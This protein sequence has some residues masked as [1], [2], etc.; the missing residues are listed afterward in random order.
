MREP[1]LTL[2]VTS[3]PRA[4]SRR[5]PPSA[6]ACCSC[7]CS[8]PPNHISTNDGGAQQDARPSRATS[9]TTE[10]MTPRS[11]HNLESCTD[12]RGGGSRSPVVRE[13]R[14]AHKASLTALGPAPPPH[15]FTYCQSCVAAVS[16][17]TP[18][19]HCTAR[20]PRAPSS[21]E[22]S[23]RPEG[24]LVL[25][26]FPFGPQ[27]QHKIGASTPRPRHLPSLSPPSPPTWRGP[28]QPEA[29]LPQRV[30]AHTHA[31]RTT[32]RRLPRASAHGGVG[33][34]RAESLP[35]STHPQ[36][37]SPHHQLDQLTLMG[38][39]P[40]LRSRPPPPPRAV[41]GVSTTASTTSPTASRSICTA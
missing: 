35:P 29:A 19:S 14:T 40:W 4:C 13:L 41:S 27:L 23:P 33:M 7:C 24:A 37:R 15:L 3:Q 32:C 11:K 5:L 20:T 2:S 22:I 8:A 9:G 26:E 36:R 39:S 28:V 12:T 38:R 1:S 31:R 17:H 25:A 16:R 34:Y 6:V 10:P 30:R 21:P 18:P